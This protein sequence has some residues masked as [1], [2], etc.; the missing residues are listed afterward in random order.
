MKT[1]NYCSNCQ[2]YK[3]DEELSSFKCM[4]CNEY[5]LMKLETKDGD[6][7]I[8]KILASE[9]D[10]NDMINIPN[11]DDFRNVLGTRFNDTEAIIAL[12]EYGRV[13]IKLR[14]RVNKL[15]GAWYL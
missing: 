7:A 5:V 12:S 6:K 11:T 10:V 15:E 1:N 4:T 14:K 8:N 2:A 13:K 3:L 9:V